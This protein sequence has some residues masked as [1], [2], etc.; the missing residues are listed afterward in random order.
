MSLSKEER[1]Q[2]ILLLGSRSH[3]EAAL[4]FNRLYPERAPI[5]SQLCEQ[6]H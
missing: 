6:T 5:A 1:I 4:E 2:V 3:R